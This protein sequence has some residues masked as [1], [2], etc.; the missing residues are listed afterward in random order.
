MIKKNVARK[1]TA[2]ACFS[3]FLFFALRKNFLLMMLE[4]KIV[5]RDDNTISF[6]FEDIQRKK[7]RKFFFEETVY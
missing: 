1:F 3:V 7:N 6:S 4:N 2:G 5:R